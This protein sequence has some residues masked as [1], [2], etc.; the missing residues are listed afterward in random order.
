MK[1][2]VSARFARWR[3]GA[4]AAAVVVAAPGLLAAGCV[5][6]IGGGA[7]RGTPSGASGSGAPAGAAGAA[8]GSTGTAG[9]GAGADAPIKLPDNPTSLPMASSCT[10]PSPGPQE[11][12]RLTAAQ[13]DQ[14]LRDLFADPA[15]PTTPVFS[16]PIVLGFTADT[17]ALVV[18]ALGAQ[19]LMDQAERV[20]HWA[21]TTH[22]PQLATCTTTDATCRQQ[23]IRAF[24]KRA[25]RAPL[26][27]ARVSAYDAIFAAESSFQD[28]AEAVIGAMLQSPYFL[29]RRELGVADPA[30]PGTVALTPYEIASSLSY[31]L[32]GSMPDATLMAA[33]DSGALA[34]PAEIDRQAQR[35]LQTPSAQDAVMSFMT[36]WLNLGKLTTT[37]KDDTVFK[38]TDG[39]R[40]AMAGETRALLVDA[41]FTSNGALGDVLTAPYS[42]LN[43]DLATHYGLP[44]AGSLGSDFQKVPYAAGS[45]DAGILAHGSVLVGNAGAAE[46]SPV[47][48][49]KLVRTRLLCQDLPPPPANLDTKLK[50]PTQTETTR[51]HFEEHSSNAVCSSCHHLMDPIGFAFEHYD[52]FGRWRDQENGTP[53]DVKG[54]IFNAMP[55]VDVP[56]DGISGLSSYLATNPATNQCLVRYWAY[57]A[58]GSASW[59]G[60]ACTYDAITTDAA[61]SQTKL[62]SVLMGIVHAPRFTRRTQP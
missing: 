45:R 27:D 35:L 34:S 48:R 37:V 25:F 14:T 60:D 4:L 28:G 7:S 51:A 38:L 16:D 29:Y 20:A 61:Q 19:Q 39:L 31:L 41:V 46:S 56:V 52:A 53:V 62:K 32:T 23:F 59:D 40:A 36:G 30:Q 15:T 24:G 3:P 57:Y 2:T 47:Q 42:F 58:F 33:A 44:Q 1:S 22:L 10:T 26:T 8:A 13:Y 12:R 50:P 55:G 43:H 17:D 54:T 18:Q 6:K 11:L 49:G 5:G 9:G 21:V